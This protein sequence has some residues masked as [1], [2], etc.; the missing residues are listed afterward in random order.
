ME[1]TACTY[2]IGAFPP[3][4]GYHR[5]IERKAAA[6]LHSM[7]GNHGFVDGNKRTAWLLAELLIERSGYVLDIADD[8]PID[9][10]VVAIAAGGMRFDDLTDWFRRAAETTAHAALTGPVAGARVLRWNGDGA[11][12][13]RAA[14]T[15]LCDAFNAHDLDRI[16]ALLRRR[17]R[18]GDAARQPALGHALRRQRRPCARPWPPAS[19]ACPTSTTAT[20]STSSTRPPT[21]AS[22]NGPSPAP[23]RPG[24]NG[25][26][27]LRLLHL[28]RR[29]GD[30]QGLLLEDRGVGLR[31]GAAPHL[32]A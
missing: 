2:R 10:L 14:L 32:L 17:L 31:T 3:Y 28:S 13:L 12:D 5:S 11:M 1:S 22:R 9:D 4:S 18:A 15:E 16:M 26:P 8:T 30:P 20:P 6:I 21:P 23:R 27:R 19:R 7:I 29:Q 24:S 25:G